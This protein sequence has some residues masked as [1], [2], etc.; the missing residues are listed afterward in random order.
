MP[1]RILSW[2]Q[3]VLENDPDWI[4]GS[5]NPIVWEFSNGRRFMDPTQ[6]YSFTSGSGLLLDGGFLVL[7]GTESITTI[8]TGVSGAIFSNGG[9]LCTSLNTTYQPGLSAFFPAMVLDQILLIGAS[10]WPKSAP[11]SG[12]GQIW[13]NGGFACVA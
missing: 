1:T 9:F 6:L 2:Q 10:A 5:L 13:N 7:D 8:D 12:T 3:L 11:V 4:R